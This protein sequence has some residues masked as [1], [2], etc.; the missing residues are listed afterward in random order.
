M[1]S[2]FDRR[3]AALV[4]FA[5]V[6]PL[7]LVLIFGIIE[8]G[9]IIY[10][11][12]MVTNA[13]REGARTGIVFRAYDSTNAP[14]P[15]VDIGKKIPITDPIIQNIIESVV[16]GYVG[17]ANATAPATKLI[18]FRDPKSINL[19][20]TTLNIGTDPVLRLQVGYTYDF[21]MVPSFISLIPSSINLVSESTMR[22]EG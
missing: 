14:D 6:L 21:L 12:A 3:G 10:D 9:I 15:D 16:W 5:L 17:Q 18:S 20:I 22:I 8:F 4:E 11:K 7:L 2:L 1:K 13:V 19:S